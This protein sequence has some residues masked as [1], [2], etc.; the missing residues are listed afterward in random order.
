MKMPHGLNDEEKGALQNVIR[1]HNA[2]YEEKKQ[3]LSK[4]PLLS[5]HFIKNQE[6][7]D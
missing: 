5:E 6:E 2:L 4:N 3:L 1:E 7:G